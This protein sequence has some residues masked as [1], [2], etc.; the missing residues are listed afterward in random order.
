MTSHGKG[1][2]TIDQLAAIGIV[3]ADGRTV[4]CIRC[5][6]ACMQV[7]YASVGTQFEVVGERDESGLPYDF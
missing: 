3:H 2:R 1:Q 4:R 5:G 7:A 6:T